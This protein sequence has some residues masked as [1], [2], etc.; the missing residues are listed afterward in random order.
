MAEEK[1]VRIT[2]WPEKPAT[3][4]H[5]FKLEKPCPV[6][7]SF[8]DTP[9]QVVLR[10]DPQQ[11][12][13]VNMSMDL[14]ADKP[15]PVCLSICE[16]ICVDSDY[17]I[18]ISIFDNPFSTIRVR[19]R[20][21]LFNCNQ[22]HQPEP[23]LRCIDFSR[24]LKPGMEID[25]ALEYM[26]LSFIPLGETIRTSTIGEPEDQ[27]KLAFPREGMRIAFP[28]PVSNIELVINNYA[29]PRLDFNVYSNSTLINQFSENIEN[30]VKTVS[31]NENDVTAI[32]IRGG[33]NEASLVSVCYT[34]KIVSQGDFT[35][36]IAR[37][38]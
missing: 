29:S 23:E 5:T 8:A 9:A 33:D 1:D 20:S 3:L 28:N 32:E 19:G 25:Q 18:G 31:I 38:S 16:P 35:H 30:T 2:A 24:K 15:V 36:N 10:T 26:G 4:E 17:T 13:D 11:K 34:A 7:I 37:P 21:R 12:L 27:V 14:K 22:Q 6:S